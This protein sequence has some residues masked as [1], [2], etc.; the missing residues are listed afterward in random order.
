VVDTR[1]SMCGAKYMIDLISTLQVLMQEAGFNTHL[2]S[3]DRSS[4][5]CFE[6]D[7]LMGFGCIFD[8]PYSLLTRWKTMELS[9]LKS[10]A[11]SLY[12]AGEK[13]WNVYLLLLCSLDAD[14]VQSLEVSWIEENLDRTRK[15][16]ACGISSREELKRAL[17][18]VLPI[19]FKSA[20]H[21]EDVTERLKTRIQTIAP[22]ASQVVL[23][24]TVSVDEVVR[25]LRGPA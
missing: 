11:P 20:L 24:E 6:D 19:Q 21:P 5:V 13:A 9:I 17:L 18:P 2:I 10:Y 12:N 8:S 22:K 4:V 3:I 16:A 23:D 15:I 1:Q 7:A 25:L 14:P